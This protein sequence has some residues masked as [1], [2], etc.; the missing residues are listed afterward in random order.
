MQTKFSWV[1][2]SMHA[3]I[4]HTSSK[5]TGFNPYFSE[6][7]YKPHKPVKV[8]IKSCRFARESVSFVHV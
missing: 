8:G 3:Q 5:S 2:T 4:K 6:H 7:N 1:V